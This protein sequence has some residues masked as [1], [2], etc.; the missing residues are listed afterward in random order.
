MSPSRIDLDMFYATF[1]IYVGKTDINPSQPSEK[2]QKLETTFQ[3]QMFE[4]VKSGKVLEF[5]WCLLK[6]A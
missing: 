2:L 1:H 4:F 5:E 3:L 6:S